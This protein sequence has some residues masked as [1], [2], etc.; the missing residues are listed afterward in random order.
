MRCWFFS[1]ASSLGCDLDKRLFI[2]A[3]SYSASFWWAASFAGGALRHL[4]TLD[5][6]EVLQP[7]R[8]DPAG[9]WR[10]RPDRP[11]AKEK[12]LYGSPSRSLLE[13]RCPDRCQSALATMD[14]RYSESV[15]RTRG[16]GK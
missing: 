2:L 6:L 15:A 16:R 13:Y 7:P 3:S 11:S 9:E 4:V 10:V 12:K 8:A 1:I 14:R 5:G